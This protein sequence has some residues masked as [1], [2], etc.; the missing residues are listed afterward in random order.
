MRFVVKEN[1]EQIWG[2]CGRPIEL[3]AARPRQ[4]AGRRTGGPSLEPQQRG[5]WQRARSSPRPPR[6]R[7]L[8][9]SFVDL[10][11]LRLHG[12]ERPLIQRVVHK[13]LHHL[14][15]CPH[16]ARKAGR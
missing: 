7:G 6:T 14:R 9:L 2:S 1:V 3:A 4:W 16:A 15:A 8:R 5:W 13:Y 12:R 11:A 10:P